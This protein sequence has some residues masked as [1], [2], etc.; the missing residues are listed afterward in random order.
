MRARALLL[1]LLALPAGAD[2]DSARYFLG[3]GREA[4]AAGDLDAAADFLKKSLEEKEG[5]VPT[6]VALG[7]L[8][9]KQGRR[10]DAIR[11]LEEALARKDRTDLS[12]P[13][14]EA[15]G[16]AETL[17]AQIDTART[18]YQA[19]VAAYTAEV[20]RL[21]AKS[22]KSNPDLA[23]ECWRVILLVDPAHP[24]AREK[25]LGPAEAGEP[26]LK[27]DF[28]GWTGGPPAWAMS[29]GVLKAHYAGAA[30]VNRT[31]KEMKGDFALLCEARVV[32]DDGSDPLFGILFGV[33]GNYDHFG[34]WIWPE[35]WRLERQF[36]E[37]RRSDLRRH[38]FKLFPG[39]YRREDW[40]TYR[41]VVKG[42]KVTCFVDGE[43]V[44]SSTAADRGLD[45]HVGFWVQDQAVEIRRFALLAP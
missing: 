28:E 33:K 10:D 17:L 1:A 16:A 23:K 15:L 32:K 35:S 18:E 3:R 34:F 30:G 2:E 37:N 6:L 40:H 19:M 4:L 44:F 27:D 31:V 12:A 39:E 9:R 14:R 43:E 20:A 38:T 29:G 36:E 24:A 11:H 26:L 5:Y 22:E 7:E 8:A 13:E 41:I 42:K 45:G 25:V 21:A